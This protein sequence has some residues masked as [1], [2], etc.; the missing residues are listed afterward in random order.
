M[1]STP[2][3]PIPLSVLDLAHVVTGSTPARA[4][5]DTLDLA[6]H[7]ERLGYVRFWVAEHHGS[8]GVAS[9][10]PAVLIAHLADA[11]TTLRVGSGGVM[12]PNHPP[13]VAAEQFGMLEALHPG[14][15]D[16]GLG[17]AP[18]TDP[19]TEKALRRPPFAE[20]DFPGQVGELLEYFGPDGP[21]TATPAAG[22]RPEVWL[23]GSSPNSATLA[24]RLGLPFAYAHHFNA[25]ATVP[26]LAAYRDA[27]QPVAGHDR[28][29]AI[30]AALVVVAETAQRAA[31]LA[32]PNGLNL[33]RYQGGASGPFPTAAEA[34]AYPYAPAE[35]ALVDS[36]LGAQLI[37][38][39]GEVRARAAGLMAASGADELMALTMLDDHQAT[40]RSY[41]LLAEAFAADQAAAPPAVR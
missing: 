13:L 30:L 36:V 41:E 3:S 23:L 25:R 26:A 32:A 39:P 17:R 18:G 31:W 4:L 35:R 22:N 34:A 37:G 20:A 33:L 9:S 27:F 12:L 38:T 5:R 6:R 7:V 19:R 40:L 16:L 24:G 14:R 2:G 11:T 1:T 29:Y 21:I 10:A 15:I 28:P 8:A